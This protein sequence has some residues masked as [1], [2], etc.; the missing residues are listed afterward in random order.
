MKKQTATTKLEEAQLLFSV[1]VLT[2]MQRHLL[3]QCLES[4][5][6]QT[7]P[8]IELIV[9]DD[10]SSDFDVDEV[11]KY[12]NE[13]KGKNIKKVI[14]YKQPKNA[15]TVKN[16]QQGVE[17][18]SG[19]F[20]KLHAGDDM[21]LDE[22]V[23]ERV[24]DH[25]RDPT[26][27][28]LAGRSV[29]CQNDGTMTGDY[30]PAY[31]SVAEMMCGDANRQFELLSSQSWGEFIN[32]P[33]VFW[34]RSFFDTLGGFDLTYKYTEDWP[35]WLKITSQGY[36]INMVNEVFTIY[37]YGGI[38]NDLSG[39]NMTLGKQH[40]QECIRMFR[41]IAIPVFEKEGNKRKV[42][43]CKHCIRCLEVRK[44]IEGGCWNDWNCIQRVGWRI[45]NI[46]F[47]L[48][49]WLY[50]KRKYGY[51]VTHKKPLFAAMGVC[52]LMYGCQVVPIPGILG[53]RVWAA[54]FFAA[55]ALLL[56]EVCFAGGIRLFNV[57]LNKRNRSGT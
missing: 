19:D 38:S 15:G 47:L 48:E 23:I 4:I 35:M 52:A 57:I 2:Y 40:Y 28:I 54:V 50:R 34:K 22:N 3:E 16:A 13:N 8:S 5:F 6:D 21:L 29:A 9:C 53:K 32:A 11:K 27:N 14:V 33:A 45:K 18:S 56:I 41:E 46:P 49:S 51:A 43:R 31:A 42:S 20:F 24:L 1:I 12:I 30:Y 36:R 37:R 26:V 44:D 7:Y 39:L 17:L 55:A 25:F 10:C